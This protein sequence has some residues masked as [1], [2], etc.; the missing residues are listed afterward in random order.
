MTRQ[1]NAALISWFIQFHPMFIHDFFGGLQFNL[2][3]R[4]RNVLLY[5]F[6]SFLHICVLFS[7][8]YFCLIFLHSSCNLRIFDDT[9]LNHGLVHL[10]RSDRSLLLDL[11]LSLSGCFSDGM[12]H[13]MGLRYRHGALRT[14]NSML[15]Y[16]L[17][18]CVSTNVYLCCY[19]SSCIARE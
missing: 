3:F 17:I 15:E 1:L 16:S 10:W 5:W 9:L 4:K 6:F 14:S 18:I 7:V 13:I 8:R 19:R 12:C 11:Q 2:K